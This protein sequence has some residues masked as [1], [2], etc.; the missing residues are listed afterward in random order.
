MVEG[1]TYSNLHEPLATTMIKPLTSRF[2]DTSLH[3]TRSLTFFGGT[4]EIMK[5]IIGRSLGI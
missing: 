1:C 4:T 2:Y 3:H 5:E